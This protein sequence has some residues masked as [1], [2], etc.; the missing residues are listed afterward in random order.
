ME[1][2]TYTNFRQN[3]REMMRKVN[4]DAERLVV[5]TNDD[6]NIVVMAQSDYDSLMETVYLIRSAENRRHITK[7]IQQLENGMG[8]EH[9]LL[10]SSPTQ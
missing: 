8:T 3:L 4:D 9:E 6:T 7:S 5:T 10:D 1:S 2:L